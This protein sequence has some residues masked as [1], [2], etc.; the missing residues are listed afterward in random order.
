MVALFG[1]QPF[2]SMSQVN[3]IQ[4]ILNLSLPN[5][6]HDAVIRSIDANVN[7]IKIPFDI[8]Y[9]ELL[10]SVKALQ[11]HGIG[12]IN[13]THHKTDIYGTCSSIAVWRK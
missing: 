3:D 8:S 4:N 10:N 9:N 12:I 6:N 5:C 2:L 1:G 11:S 13:Y 7:L